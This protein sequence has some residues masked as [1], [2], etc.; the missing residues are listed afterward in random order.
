MT[1][2]LLHQFNPDGAYAHEVE[3]IAGERRQVPGR[4]HHKQARA[5][6]AIL[7]DIDDTTL[8]TYS[9]EIYSNFVYNPTTNG[10]FVNAGSAACSRP[11]PGMVDLEKKAIA[12][13]LQG[14]LPD[15]PPGDRS[16]T[17]TR[18]QPGRR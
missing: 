15:R 18:R 12:H 4:S 11:C 5:G 3:G 1:T 17:G 14:V 10:A 7:F 6:K 2:S 16:A 8:N 13:G 9:Y